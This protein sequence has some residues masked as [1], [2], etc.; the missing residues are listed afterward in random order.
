MAWRAIDS[1]RGWLQ[2]RKK[3]LVG[4]V[5]VAA[6]EMAALCPGG[7]I[8]VKLV[9]ELAEHGID[10]LLKKEEVPEVKPA[11]QPFPP[12][13][14][15][16]INAWLGKL[17]A[18]Y[19]GLLGELEKRT[20]NADDD[21]ITAVIREALRDRADLQQSFAAFR[22]DV[23]GM[24][25]SLIRVEAKLDQFQAEFRAFVLN[26]PGCL[27]FQQLS[28]PARQ[29]LL[30]SAQHFRAGRA[31]EGAE[32]LI[33]SLPSW[34]V[35]K[36]TV[37]RIVAV[38]FPDQADSARAGDIEVDEEPSTPTQGLLGAAWPSPTIPSLPPPAPG[39][40][41]TS[42]GEGPCWM[43]H[44]QA[45]TCLAFSPDG[46]HVVSGGKEG[47]V[48]KWDAASGK[49]VRLFGPSVK[50]PRGVKTRLDGV[51]AVTYSRNGRE[52]LAA[53]EAGVIL[54]W[55]A[56]NGQ[57]IRRVGEDIRKHY[58]R[59]IGAA[60]RQVD[61]LPATIDKAVFSADGRFALLETGDWFHNGRVVHREEGTRPSVTFEGLF[62]AH[63]LIFLDLEHPD[64]PKYAEHPW[65]CSQLD[66]SNVYCL[67]H[68][69]IGIAAIGD[70]IAYSREDG[71]DPND[72]LCVEMLPSGSGLGH[73]LP[74][75]DWNPKER[76]QSMAFS[77]DG[78]RLLLGRLDGC[79]WLQPVHSKTK[80]Y[81]PIPP[82]PFRGHEGAVRAVA[83]SP[84]G[85]RAVSGGE[86]G[87]VRVWCVETGNRLARYE[88]HTAPI[89]SVAC[90]PNGLWVASGSN[91][92]T[93]RV[94]RFPEVVSG[95]S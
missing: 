43:G 71:D 4:L 81:N 39:P 35:G 14:L 68:F 53:V 51:L 94:W 20:A 77:P 34:G 29:A 91:D 8:A 7:G 41:G 33:R 93:V 36:R 74:P 83:F 3:L 95:P 54:A 80:L 70:C 56:E 44:P 47:T 24:T 60:E 55:D 37:L 26:F 27:E 30:Q 6:E 28:A 73:G 17:T 65:N 64:D 61:E 67:Q 1:I 15:D 82:P 46:K 57:V 62:G 49:E 78:S 32:V 22:D 66:D 86:D 58:F 2:T 90:S 31:K 50:Y 42:R 48:R 72:V 92:G 85:R 76:I 18:G 5:G 13:R 9:K 59:S 23:Q 75:R 40:V 25:L 89:T 88:G 45:V 63:D 79:L 12:E 38:A 21:R 19:Q 84:T 52:V 16:E 10:R 69:S 11:G 87:T